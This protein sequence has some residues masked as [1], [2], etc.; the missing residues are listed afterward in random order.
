MHVLTKL[1]IQTK[2]YDFR[3]FFVNLK[4]II[5]KILKLYFTEYCIIYDG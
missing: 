4:N 1:G 3:Y 2:N 5:L